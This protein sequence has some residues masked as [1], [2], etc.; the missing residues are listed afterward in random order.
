MLCS[1]VRFL[2]YAHTF[3][4]S[5]ACVGGGGTS[6][7][8]LGVQAMPL[9]RH[10]LQIWERGKKEEQERTDPDRH[11]HTLSVTIVILSEARFATYVPVEVRESAPRTTPPSYWHAMMVVCGLGKVGRDRKVSQTVF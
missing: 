6:G 8:G 4:V 7:E 1:S 11:I 5:A 3:W 10:S 2:T 9:R